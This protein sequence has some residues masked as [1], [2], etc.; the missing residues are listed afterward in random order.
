M[1]AATEM[2]PDIEFAV[3][4][5]AQFS[6]DPARTHWEATKCIIR[7]LKGMRD[8]ELTYGSSNTR[9]VRYTD[10]DHA[11]QY[12]RHSISGY[13]FLVNGGTVSWSS[14]KQSVMALST[15]EAEYVAATHTMKEALWLQ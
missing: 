15:T 8:L 14:K 4:A 5:L 9:I 10:A 2:W 12:H 6:Q 7:Y 11:S 13:T 3:L 1:Y